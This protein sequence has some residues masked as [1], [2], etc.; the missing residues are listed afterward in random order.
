MST[1]QERQAEREKIV[2]VIEQE[3]RGGL[4]YLTAFDAA[5]NTCANFAADAVLAALDAHR[6]AREEEERGEGEHIVAHAMLEWLSGFADF[7]VWW[8]GMDERKRCDL[9]HEMGEHVYAALQKARNVPAP[10]LDNREPEPCAAG[11]PC[12]AAGLLDDWT[13]PVIH[14]G[15]G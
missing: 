1:L 7:R 15:G 11:L 2:A 9:Y 12:D 13:H 8:Y 4:Q 6:K 3:I 14:G 10:I 5:P